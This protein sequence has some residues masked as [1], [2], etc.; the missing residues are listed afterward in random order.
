MIWQGFFY[1]FPLNPL[2]GA[3]MNFHFP[4]SCFP[5]PF[6]PSFL[7]RRDSRSIQERTGKQEV[8]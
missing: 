5:I 4:P 8:G 6:L 3:A 2:Y 7:L 1:F